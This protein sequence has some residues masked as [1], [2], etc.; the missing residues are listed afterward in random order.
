MLQVNK[1][2]INPVGKEPAITF[3]KDNNSKSQV[4]VTH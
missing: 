4:H 2:I 3:L 1:Y